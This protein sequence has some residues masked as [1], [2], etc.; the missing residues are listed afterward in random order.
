VEITCDPAKNAKNL[1]DRG[2][3]FNDA[4]QLF[5][6][7]TLDFLDDRKDYGEPR[8][9]TVGFLQGRMMVV[10]WTQRGKARHIISMRKAN[11]REQKRFGERFGQD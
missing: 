6:G 1:E 11:E 9:I 3:D 10:V 7:L 8:T 4:K 5:A 2:I